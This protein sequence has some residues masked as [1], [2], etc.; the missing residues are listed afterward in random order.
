MEMSRRKFSSLTLTFLK[1]ILSACFRIILI[2]CLNKHSWNEYDGIASLS[3]E[4]KVSHQ[5]SVTGPSL[6]PRL[7]RAYNLSIPPVHLKHEP[8]FLSPNPGQA[9]SP[10][11]FFSFSKRLLSTY[12]GPK[13]MVTLELRAHF[14]RKG[15][16]I[17]SD[18]GRLLS[19]CVLRLSSRRPPDSAQPSG[20][21]WD[22]T[23]P[24]TSRPPFC[25]IGCWSSG[26]RRDHKKPQSGSVLSA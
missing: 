10:C 17:L 5:E 26:D 20:A 11:S 24:C 12:Y 15:L 9:F 19:S 8:N 18:C 6:E 4:M 14:L 1:N 3:S 25:Y 23:D 13:A 22:F 7:R 16:V 2:N 21:Q